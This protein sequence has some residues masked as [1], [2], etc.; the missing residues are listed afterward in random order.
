MAQSID[1]LVELEAVRAF[2]RIVRAQALAEF[3]GADRNELVRIAN[4]EML[5]A[6]RDF[7]RHTTAAIPA[8]RLHV[9]ILQMVEQAA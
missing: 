4:V 5:S 9:R 1:Q 2:R 7:D 3:R 8:E 6:K